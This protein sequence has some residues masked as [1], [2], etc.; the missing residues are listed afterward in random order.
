VFEAQAK[1]EDT[2]KIILQKWVFKL[3][4]PKVGYQLYSC[5]G[6]TGHVLPQPRPLGIDLAQNWHE[7]SR[8]LKESVEIREFEGLDLV[9]GPYSKPEMS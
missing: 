6:L 8:Q 7:F 1:D 4:E 5:K 9:E 2:V 3:V